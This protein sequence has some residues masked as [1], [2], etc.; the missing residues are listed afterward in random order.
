MV[1]IMHD[2]EANDIEIERM[3]ENGI[4]AEGNPTY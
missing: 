2:G 1:S 3:N 4:T